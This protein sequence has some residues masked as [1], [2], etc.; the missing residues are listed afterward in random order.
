MRAH[1]PAAAL[2]TMV[3]GA[4]AVTTLYCLQLAGY[5]VMP[6]ELG[7][8]QQAS[9]IGDHL[10]PVLPSDPEF[11]SWSQ[12]QPLLLA[13]PYALFSTPVAFDVAHAVNAVAMASSAIPAY[14]L[15]RRLA[16][17]RPAAYLAAGLTVAVPWMTLA[18]TMLTENVAYPTFLW[19]TYAAL[20][21]VVDAR[22]RND[23]LLV[24]ALALA[25][26][27]RTQLSLLAAGVAVAVVVHEVGWRWRGDPRR[28]LHRAVAE[29]LVAAVRGH[30][31]LAGL[32]AIGLAVALTSTSGTLLGGYAAP[33]EGRLLPPG[34]VDQAVEILAQIVTGIGVLP[35]A[36]AIA[37]AVGSL[38]RPATREAHAF[39]ALA[40]PTIV[41]MSLALG[42]FSVRFTAGV[43]DRYLFF[44]APILFCGS[45]AFLLERRRWLVPLAL[46][47]VGASALVGAATMAQRGPS[48]VSPAAAF[49]DILLDLG[50]GGLPTTAVVLG[51][52]GVL[53]VG[54]ARV[55]RPDRRRQTLALGG[56]VLAF[57][58]VETLYTMQKIGEGQTTSAEYLEGRDWLDR[59]LPGDATAAVLLADFNGDHYAS[60]A[61]WWDLSFW[62]MDADHAVRFASSDDFIQ[63]TTFPL[64]LDPER[65]ALYG[66]DRR[67][68]VVAETDR[69]LGLRDAQRV[70]GRYGMALLRL[71]AQPHA[72]YVLAG[73]DSAGR[74]APGG[75]ALLY[76]FAPGRA[77]ELVLRLSGETAPRDYRFRVGRHRGTVRK[78]GETTVR[79]PVAAPGATRPVIVR[80]DV[81]GTAPAE[82][83][84]DPGPRVVGV[85]LPG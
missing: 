66:I 70:D 37:F 28:P 71:P 83:A 8:V 17:W 77:G 73:T 49:H 33:T 84:N 18:G 15:M 50:I 27:A 13:L 16:P 29:G 42:S 56:V 41:F 51:L 72:S 85:T 58:A 62:N 30:L 76:L 22:P 80:L 26:L 75:A 69:R 5:F 40:I 74:V 19:A 21:A 35:L 43:N 68:L 14:L 12:L 2:T 47:G 61:T 45:L 9:F 82:P 64:T 81:P 57:C 10:R 34:T 23:L 6:D 60:S 20:V 4:A 65:G 1:G 54:A 59:T 32:S 53:A 63:K 79:V 11:G 36:L 44:L 78:G 38:A 55:L 3:V 48:L 7:Y 39:A 25:Y 46:G 52:V 67:Y 31:V 24:A